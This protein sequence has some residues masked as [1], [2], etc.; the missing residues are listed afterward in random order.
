VLHVG[1]QR[2]SA[3]AQMQNCFQIQMP[4]ATKVCV[5]SVTHAAKALPTVMLLEMETQELE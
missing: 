2:L 1:R 4:K 5:T 3:A